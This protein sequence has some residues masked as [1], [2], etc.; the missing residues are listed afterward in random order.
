MGRPPL[1]SRHYCSY[2]LPLDLR[3]EDIMESE[4]NVAIVKA[5]LDDNGWN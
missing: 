2:A 1:L 3:D 4:E 5:K